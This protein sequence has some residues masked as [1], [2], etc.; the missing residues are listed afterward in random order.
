[1]DTCRSTCCCS[2]R[3]TPCRTTGCGSSCSAAPAGF[4]LHEDWGTTPAAIDACLTRRRRVRRAGGDPHRHAQRGGLRRVDAGGDRR[5]VDPHVPHRGRGRRPRARHHHRRRAS[6]R[7]AVVDQPDPAAHGQHA[8]RAPRHVDGV[9][10]PQPVGARGPG[11]RREPHPPAHD[12]RRGR[13][14]RP[15]RDLDHRQR[16]AGDGPRR[17]GDP[18]HVA[19]RARDEGAGAARCP[20]TA[21]PT[22]TGPAATS[23]STRSARRC[24]H[25]IDA[26]GRLGRGR[27]ARRPRAV[28]PAVL[29]RAAARRGQGRDDRVGGDGRRQRVDPDAAAGAARGRCSARRRALPRRRASTFVAQA[30]LDDGLA[31]TARACAGRL[32]AVADTR[33]RGKADLPEN[34]AMPSIEVDPDTFAVRIDG[35]LDR[36][37][38]RRPSCPMAQRYFLF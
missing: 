3:A 5:P 10:S 32:V 4:K 27:Q 19:D 21:P 13:A 35:E 25:G 23:R 17:R 24:A 31:D 8:R 20:A 26:R 36:G 6:Q 33:S 9:P 18:A 14:P 34:D 22:T 11:L 12:R 38:A 37:A 30:A 1:M 15:G 28:G 29:R 16:L 2:A 7:A